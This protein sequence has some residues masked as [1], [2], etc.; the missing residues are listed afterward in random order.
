MTDFIAEVLKATEE[1]ESPRFYFYWSALAAISAVVRNNVYLSKGGLYRLYP[2]IYVIL[3]GPS[4]V[5]KGLPVSVAKKLVNMVGNTRIISGINSIEKILTRLGTAQTLENGTMIKDGTALL[6]N[7]EL[8]TMV[9][10]NPM[11]QTYLTTLY[12]THQHQDTGFT[13]DTKS[14]G[15]VKIIKPYITILGASNDEHFQDFLHKKSLKGGFI[16]RCLIHDEKIRSRIN[17]L[18]EDQ[19][20]IDFVYLASILKKISLIEGKFTYSP[21]SKL[22]FEDWYEELAQSGVENP[23]SDP[24]GTKNRIHDQMLKVAMLLSLSREHGLILEIEDINDAIRSCT[25]FMTL[26]KSMTLGTGEHELSFKTG[27]FIQD[28][29]K[30]PNYTL[31]QI[32]IIQRRFGEMNVEDINRIVDTLEKGE[33]IEIIRVP[34]LAFRLTEK[35]VKE[36]GGIGKNED[37]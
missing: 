14:G 35:A 3:K 11:S 13:Y 18:T 22:A 28:L 31:T 17:P 7:D 20:E 24:T 12:D 6:V 15:E 33:L 10:D 30:A 34:K 2:N 16:A 29:L 23:D 36:L 25:E 9:L 27:L 26:T 8:S 37:K 4:G 32:K 21:A 19:A 5:R 1:A